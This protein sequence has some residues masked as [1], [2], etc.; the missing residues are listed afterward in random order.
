[1]QIA[2]QKIMTEYNANVLL[3]KR[4]QKQTKCNERWHIGYSDVNNSSLPC[5]RDDSVQA[6]L[7]DPVFPCHGTA[8]VLPPLDQV[9]P[10]LYDNMQTTLKEEKA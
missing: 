10:H 3:C 8:T 5:H 9:P 2:M 6:S 7:R 4:V 1:M